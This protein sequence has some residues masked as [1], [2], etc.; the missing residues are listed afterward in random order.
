MFTSKRFSYLHYNNQSAEI[1][2]GRCMVNT[3]VP[4]PI[5]A[6]SFNSTLVLIS[7]SRRIQG[8]EIGTLQRVACKVSM[9]KL[10]LAH[11][12]PCKWARKKYAMFFVLIAT[13]IN[14]MMKGSNSSIRV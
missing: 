2:S 7:E 9:E 13:M 14:A 5:P 10:I 6:S 11:T 8:P 12:T 1:K 3:N 4:L